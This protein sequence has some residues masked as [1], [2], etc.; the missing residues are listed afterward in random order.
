MKK[1]K[2]ILSVLIFLSLLMSTG[3]FAA[4]EEKIEKT[5]DKKDEVRFKLVLGDCQLEKSSDGR[6]HVHLVYSYG[7]KMNYVPKL[8]ERGDTLYLEEKI[9]EKNPRG[10]SRWTVAIPDETEIDFSSASG[11]LFIEDLDLKIDGYTG[12]GEIDLKKVRGKF[13]LISGTGRVKVSDS[14]GNFEVRSGTG[15]VIIE[16]CRGNFDASSGTS[17][18][19]A[20]GLTIEY[21]GDFDSG[22]GD[23]E[24][25]FPDGTDFELTLDS[26][27][28]DAVLDMKGRSIEGYFELECQA[29][30]GRIISPV[31]FDDEEEYGDDDQKYFRKSFTKGNGTPK[32]YIRTGTGKAKLIK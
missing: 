14:E 11:N 31:K 10:Y 25:A 27:T 5:F 29:K 1:T 13:D 3:L 17:D 15:R 2:A 26:G 24:V 8:E 19:R 4:Q 32:V 16:N 20:E 28:N 7:P 21:E 18:V 9:R 6:I 22:T 23:V 12:T 30:R